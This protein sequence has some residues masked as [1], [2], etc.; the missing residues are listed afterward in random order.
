[1]AVSQSLSF[2]ILE[3]QYSSDGNKTLVRFVW[4]ST[5]SG[6]SFNNNTRTAQY[7]VTQNGVSKTYYVNYTLPKNSTATIVD[8]T[9]TVDHDANGYGS[10]TVNTWMD[11]GISAGVVEKSAT[12]TAPRI[13]PKSTLVVSDGTLGTAQNVGV[14]RK[15]KSFTHT[16]TYTCGSVSGTICTKSS[17]EDIS[18]TPPINLAEQAPSANSVSV[19][20]ELITYEGNTEIGIDKKSIICTIP[21]TNDFVPVLIFAPEDATGYAN[22][23]GAYI[24]GKS[25]LKLDIT[26][27]GAY[28]AWIVAC[29]TV[30]DGSMY[31]GTSVVSNP[32]I[33]SGTIPIKVVVTDSRARVTEV[34][35]TINV[36][37]YQ[38][39]KI[40][41]FTA[42]RCDSD[43]TANTSGSYFKAAFSATVFS[44]NNK[45]TARYWVGYKK[46]GATK[47]AV[48]LTNLANQYSVNSSYVFQADESS[49]DVIFTVTDAFGTA[50][51]T[52]TG[53]ALKKV[54]S[55]LKSGNEIVGMAF[56][57]TAEE[58]GILDIGWKVRFFD[59]V[60]GVV[61][62]NGT[63]LNT[64]VNGGSYLVAGWVFNYS[65]VPEPVALA[66][67]E[68]INVVG[69]G[70][71][72][73][74]LQRFTMVGNSSTA[75]GEISTTYERLRSTAGE[76]TA[77]VCTRGDFVVEQGTKD[78]WTYRKWNSG[79]AECWKTLT[80]TTT[81][82]T[83]WNS[84][85]VGNA[86]Q[87]Q[88]YPFSFIEKPV[89]IVTLTS[90]GSMGF[91]YPEQSGHGVNGA[92]ASARYNVA[93]LSSIT[94]SATFYFNYQVTGKWR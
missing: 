30:F 40:N 83:S 29:K 85:Y 76:W 82:A 46:A 51:Q 69:R 55:M 62:P 8:T 58:E 3:Q 90:G 70:I 71:T 56:G 45:N 50:T 19:S 5:Q 87:R 38:H 39:P 10:L 42:T 52:I 68:V 31:T 4:T 60:A 33:N 54:M 80:H 9:L 66:Y 93:S 47:T 61:L 12:Y 94:T 57:K 27:Y 43:G 86:T 6:E 37:T 73:P 34:N 64:V 74:I 81:V 79:L 65:N 75:K 16:I 72:P 13:A 92:S 22:T 23:Y 11:T 88:N 18:W 32:I 49:Y 2:S 1:M 84:M 91:I 67:L 25:K 7:T 63:D 15:N 53:A 20:F 21:E 26:T 44:L 36:L 78:G 59:G 48:E 24:Q 17:A 41:S 77:W 28:G 14:Y 35:T 89:E